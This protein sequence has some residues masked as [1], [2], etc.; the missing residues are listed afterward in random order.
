MNKK[1]VHLLINDDF[2]SFFVFAGL[3]PNGDFLQG[4]KP[5][6]LKGT[7]VT[8]QDA[9]P[10][11]SISG[12]VEYIK[13][14]QKQGDMVLVVPSGASAVRLGNNASIKQ[15]VKL[16]KGLYSLTFNAARTCAQEQKINVSVI[17]TAEKNDWGVFPIQTVYSSNG[18]DSY[19]CGFNADFPEVDIVIHNPGK[20]EDPACGPLIDSVALRLLNPP[21]LGRGKFSLT[22]FL[23]RLIISL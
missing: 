22:N 19:A 3:L 5:S 15:K 13:A 4:P 12:Y 21:R 10:Q 18:W 9:I 1:H 16:V 8:S 14:G 20:S 11:W 7:V 6:Q 23:L 2:F 17:P